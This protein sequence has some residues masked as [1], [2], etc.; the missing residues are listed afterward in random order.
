MD[1]VEARRN[2]YTSMSLLLQPIA[3]D[4]HKCKYLLENSDLSI[5]HCLVDVEPLTVSRV[6]DSLLSGLEDYTIDERGDVGS[7]VRM[8]CIQSLTRVSLTMLSH[9][10]DIPNFVDYFPPDK[11]QAAIAGILKQGA[12]RL[13]NVRQQAGENLLLLLQTPLPDTQDAD[14][15]RVPGDEILR[16]TLLRYTFTFFH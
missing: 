12:E 5:D 8:A 6:I 9:A 1:N 16:K 13:D 14:L 15:W 7:W 10:R 3:P 2:C 11:Y 4:L